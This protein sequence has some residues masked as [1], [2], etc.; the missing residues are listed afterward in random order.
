MRKLS[1]AAVMSLGFAALALVIGIAQWAAAAQRFDV[2]QAVGV[3]HSTERFRG[4]SRVTAAFRKEARG[5]RRLGDHAWNAEEG[6]RRRNA[7]SFLL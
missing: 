3:W 5:H 1:P 4:E 2:A 6:R 7:R